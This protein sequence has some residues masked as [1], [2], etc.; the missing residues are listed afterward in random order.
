[1]KSLIT[2]FLLYDKVF[3]SRVNE[4]TRDINFYYD[5]N[6]RRKITFTSLLSYMYYELLE[7]YING[8]Y[9]YQCNKCGNYFLSRVKN[10]PQINHTCDDCKGGMK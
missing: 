1:M 5:S 6:Y 3:I 8:Y 4:K 9:P 10:H 2:N 7:D